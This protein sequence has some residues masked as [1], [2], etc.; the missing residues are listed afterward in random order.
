[1]KLPLLLADVK[2]FGLQEQIRS[3]KAL[4]RQLNDS[5][6]AKEVLTRLQALEVKLAALKEGI[7]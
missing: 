5:E 3:E 4:L 1:M 6:D 7:A 2:R